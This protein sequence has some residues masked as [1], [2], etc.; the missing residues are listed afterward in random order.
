MSHRLNGSGV[1]LEQEGKTTAAYRAYSSILPY[2]SSLSSTFA[3]N[4]QH[5]YWREMVLARYSVLISHHVL[6]HVNPGDLLSPAA[7][8]PPSSLLTPFRAYA[9]NWDSR[10]S[11]RGSRPS[12]NLR[13]WQAY[14]DTLS[15][16]VQHSIVQPIFSSRLHQ[17]TELK[18]VERIF[19]DGLLKEVSF[20]RAD[21]TSSQ[22]EGWVDQVIANWRIMCGSTW[23]AEELG[24]GGR[25]GVGQGVLDV[26][27]H[28][29]GTTSLLDHLRGSTDCN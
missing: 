12:F 23:R 14:Y 27:F 7:S 3:D 5:H 28:P 19:E 20:P 16:L 11:A 10:L 26:S 9:H 13:P 2:L 24:E 25:A 4:P 6:A 29:R 1:S 22:I 17:R 21:Q 18:T 8:I 15:R